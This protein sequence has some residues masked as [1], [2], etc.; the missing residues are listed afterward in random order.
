MKAKKMNEHPLKAWIREGGRVGVYVAAE[1]GMGYNSMQNLYRGKR[2]I[3]PEE[4]ERIVTY[5]RRAVT[6]KMLMEWKVGGVK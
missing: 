3:K 1:L 5:T 2:K 4:V 6:K